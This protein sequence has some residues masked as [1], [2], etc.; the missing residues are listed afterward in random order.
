MRTHRGRTCSWG[1]SLIELLLGLAVAA[2]I[3]VMSINHYQI[4]AHK[5]EI[6]TLKN[7]LALLFLGF[8]AY[9][10]AQTCPQGVFPKVGVDVFEEV[11][12]QLVQQGIVW[13]P[14][15][16]VRAWT[17]TVMTVPSPKSR[18]VYRL[19]LTAQM[20]TTVAARLA[21]YREV[22]SA[23]GLDSQQRLYWSQMP[24]DTGI[25]M[26]AYTSGMKGS[27]LWFRE[28]ETLPDDERCAH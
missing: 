26:Q 18:P 1:Y 11:R 22:L 20:Q 9:Y 10:H 27:A 5:I 6:E 25:T 3:T 4:Y 17:A 8:Q 28:K 7:D 21:W 24:M 13:N 15:S 12:A 19:V 23:A 16:T 14:P 2:G